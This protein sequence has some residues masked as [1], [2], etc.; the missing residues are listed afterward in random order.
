ML[1][2]TLV[3]IWPAWFRVRHYFPAVPRPDVWFAVV[4]SYTWIGVAML[5]DRLARGA[6][7][8]VL[9]FGGTAVIVEQSL[10]VAAFDSRWWRAAAQALYGW[11]ST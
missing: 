3:V 10:E 7:H 8:A 4:L 2:A 9:A 5:P 1:L 11:L 6:V